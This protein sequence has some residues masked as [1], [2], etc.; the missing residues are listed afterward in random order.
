[1]VYVSSLDETLGFFWGYA[2]LMMW[3]IQFQANSI[4]VTVNKGKL[5]KKTKSC[6][7]RL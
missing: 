2:S 4:F 1:M 5:Q 6:E 3:N 7:Q